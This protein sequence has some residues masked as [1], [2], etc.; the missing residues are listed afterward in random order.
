MENNRINPGDLDTLITV[1]S[2]TQTVGERGQKR[3]TVAKYAD[4][5]AHLDRSVN[6]TVEDDNLESAETI[7]VLMYKIPTL[8]SRWRLL[9][10]GVPYEITAIDPISRY[11]AFNIITARTIQQ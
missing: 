6:E 5:Y 3:V 11:S 10:G 7:D 1:Q 2:V 9:I 8:T 4:V